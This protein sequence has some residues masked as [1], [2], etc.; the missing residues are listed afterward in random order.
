[1][2]AANLA[3]TLASDRLVSLVDCDVEEPNLHLFFPS[4][5]TPRDVTLPIPVFDASIC[6]LCGACG[7]FCRYGA[8]SV[9]PKKLLFFPDLC[10]SCGGC[11]LLCPEHAIHEESKRIG[12]LSVS[13]PLP[14]LKLVTGTLDSGSP[15]AVPIIHAVKLE[16]E[17]DPLVILDTAPG[18]SCPVVEALEGCDACI[19]VTESTPFGLHDLELAVDVTKRLGIPAGVIINRS[20]GKDEETLRFCEQQD[21]PVLLTIPFSREIAA[22]QNRGDLLCR[23]YP[24]WQKEFLSVFSKA[25]SLLEAKS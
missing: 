9:L 5:T 4:K 13:T 3:F 20:D 1:M 7:E 10:H 24:E 23:A 6:T 11:T 19:L 25:E 18:T 8:V 15:L 17:P 12:T 2:T 21:L 14:G 22:V 16:A